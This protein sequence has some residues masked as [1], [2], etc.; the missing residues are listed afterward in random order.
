ML[1]PNDL[2][3]IRQ[4]QFWPCRAVRDAWDRHGLPMQPI[5]I[6]KQWRLMLRE[7]EDIILH[8]RFM[9]DHKTRRDA[10]GERCYTEPWSDQRKEQYKQRCR[11]MISAIQQRIRNMSE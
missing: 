9:C 11:V 10:Y 3:E 2:D 4:R 8:E 7:Y 5:P 6:S 1:N